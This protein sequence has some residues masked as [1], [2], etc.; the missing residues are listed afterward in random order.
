MARSKIPPRRV[1]HKP[2]TAL[3]AATLSV[4]RAPQ[5]DIFTSPTSV[6]AE[7]LRIVPSKKATPHTHIVLAPGNPG[8]IEYYRPLLHKLHTRL[9][10]DVRNHVS[11]HA[12]GLPGH[13]VRQLNGDTEFVIQDHVAYYIHYLREMTDM[14][15][16]FI[17]V[18]HSYGA[19]LSLRVLDSLGD[20]IARNANLV[21]LMP[22]IWQMAYCAGPFLRLLIQDNWALTSWGA[23]LATAFLPPM[24]REALLQRARHSHSVQDVTRAVVDGRRR[25]LYA[26]VTSLARDEMKRITHVQAH[27]LPQHSLTLCVDNDRWCPEDARSHIRQHFER[28][29]EIQHLQKV[30][31]A[32]VLSDSET[33]RLVRAIA[34]WIA[35]RIHHTVNQAVPNGSAS[36]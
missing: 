10:H 8:V 31:H 3:R 27:R 36:S 19:F 33:D 29:L 17:F 2:R 12:L 28:R 7:V 11:L 22:C 1:I 14:R 34:P 9:P 24:F 30:S 18:G 16:N 6:R 35:E 20:K 15:D 32:F 13:D 4:Q 23:W 5:C 26:N 25:A 21:M